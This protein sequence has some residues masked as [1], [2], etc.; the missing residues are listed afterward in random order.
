MPW[1]RKR[2]TNRSIGWVECPTV[3]ISRAGAMAQLCPGGWGSE[4]SARRFQPRVNAIRIHLSDA[5]C[6]DPAMPP[7][8][9]ANLGL[10]SRKRPGSTRG[11]GGPVPRIDPMRV[12]VTNDD[13][14]G[15]EGLHALRRA[16]I[17]VAGIETHVIVPDSN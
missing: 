13:G 4:E 9:P 14:I 3:K 11:A 1:D 2:C 10:D 6:V 8:Y 7:P 5:D 17:Q 16:L 15:A 12:L